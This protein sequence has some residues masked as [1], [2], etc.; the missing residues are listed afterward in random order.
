MARYQK[1]LILLSDRLGARIV[2]DLIDSLAE[3]WTPRGSSVYPVFPGA[4]L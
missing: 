1:G 3:V 2:H 4:G